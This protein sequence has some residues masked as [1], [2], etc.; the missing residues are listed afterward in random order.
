MLS[1]FDPNRHMGR[2][3]GAFSVLAAAA[4][5]LSGCGARPLPATE[6]PSSGVASYQLGSGDKLHVVVFGDESLTG[7]YLI[8]GNGRLALPLVGDVS[9]KGLTSAE[10]TTRLQTK[11]KDYMRDPKVSIQILTYRPVYVVGEVRSPGSY[12]YVDGMT[13]LNAVAIAGGYT[14]RAEEEQFIIDRKALGE[15]VAASPETPLVPGDVVTV[16]E[17]YF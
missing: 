17:R 13:V 6:A 1:S 3:L 8:D 7:D 9:A 12:A 10:L 2:R 14:Y 5:A 15:P 16:R 11:L 4:L